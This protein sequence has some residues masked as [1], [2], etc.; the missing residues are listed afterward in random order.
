MPFQ[1]LMSRAKKNVEIE[2]IQNQVCVYLF[3][4]LLLNGESQLTNTLTQR[5]EALKKACKPIESKIDYVIS[6]DADDF[7]AIQEFLN[8]SV[9]GSLILTFKMVA[10][11]L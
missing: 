8:E 11:D 6:K 1:V 7:D 5:R 3:D 4:C 9:K 2:T 10:K